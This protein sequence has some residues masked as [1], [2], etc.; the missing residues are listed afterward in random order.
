VAKAITYVQKNKTLE[1]FKEGTEITADELLTLEVDILVPAALENVITTKNA[2]N[3]RAKLICEGA[4]GPTTAAADPILDEKGIFVIPDI[5]A[6]AGGVTV[7]YFEWVQDRMGYF[8]SEI[9]VNSR[10]TDIMTRSFQEVLTLSKQHRVNM[11]TAA[12]MLSINRV[13]TVHRLRGIY[14]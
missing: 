9:E 14:A 7:S 11:R 5:L 4:N 10:L 12:Y 8:W 6:N 3:I 13:A 2:P 1:G